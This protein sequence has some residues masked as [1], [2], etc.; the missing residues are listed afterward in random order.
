[1]KSDFRHLRRFIPGV[2][3]QWLSNAANALAILKKEGVAAYLALPSRNGRKKPLH[4]KSLRHP[5]TTRRSESPS[6]AIIQNV[7]R[8]K[9]AAGTPGGEPG[10]II[11]A[12]V[13]MGFEA[14]R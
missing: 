9:Y 2:I 12:G 10:I 11:D 3:Y 4:L 8:R 14:R 6:G 13:F 1:M 7:L 5:F